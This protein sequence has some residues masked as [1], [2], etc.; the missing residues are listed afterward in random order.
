MVV[1]PGAYLQ[2]PSPPD[3]LTDAQ[4]DE[5]WA[6]VNRMPADWFPRETHA[7]LAQYCRHVTRCSKVGHLIDR[8]EKRKDLTPKDYALLLRQETMQSKL[9]AALATK[10]RI[11]QQ[12]TYDRSKKKP[13]DERPLPSDDEDDED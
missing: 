3:D 7:I 12:S 1:G 6:I 2:R 8:A 4:Q 11:S 10:M 9:I 5:W 13:F